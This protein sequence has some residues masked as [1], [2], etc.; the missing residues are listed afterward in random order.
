[1]MNYEDIENVN[2]VEL[3]DEDLEAVSGGKSRYI[4]GDDGKSHVRTGPGLDYKAIG[5]LHPGEEAKYLGKTATDSNG[6]VWYK[7]RWNGRDA[8]VSSR[9][10]RKVSH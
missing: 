4:R 8:W 10:T 7:I 5:V 2:V 6:R 1:M 9:Y 3:D